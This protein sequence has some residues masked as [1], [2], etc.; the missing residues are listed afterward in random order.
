[1]ANPR[2]P[3]NKADIYRSA[4]P[5]L[6]EAKGDD[7]PVAI[8]FSHGTTRDRNPLTRMTRA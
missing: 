6:K 4:I 3:T 1:L 7:L 5:V 8:M 2:I